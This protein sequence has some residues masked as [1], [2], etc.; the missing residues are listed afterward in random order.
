MN[1]ASLQL[2]RSAG[3]YLNFG[4]QDGHSLLNLTGDRTIEMWLKPSQSGFQ[5]LL[6]KDFDGYGGAKNRDWRTIMRSDGYWQYDDWDA[7]DQNQFSLGSSNKPTPGQWNYLA[8][9]YDSSTRL[10]SM[11][12]GNQANQP[13][14]DNTNT[15]GNNS[16]N[17]SNAF[18]QFGVRGP[19]Y[20]GVILDLYDGLV[21]EIR[22]W[23]IVRSL[24]DLQRNYLRQ[25]A[26]NEPGLVIYC[27]LNNVFTELANGI[28]PSPSGTPQ[29]SS[30]VPFSDNTTTSTSTTT[31]STSTSTTT[32]STSTTT[33]STS[34][35]TTTTQTSTSTSSSTTTTSTSTTT[36][37][38]STTTST[39]TTLTSTS[40]TTTTSTS[41][42][43]T[44]TIGLRFVVERV[45]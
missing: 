45:K 21:D 10:A 24:S 19:T 1:T 22:M 27:T 20:L 5:S 36:T 16:F 11:Y 12:L 18:V 28:T 15:R 23:N 3:Q 4:N 17:A 7:N 25:L 34:T 14:L 41:T 32:T 44:V 31:T 33:T 13:A 43:T 29:F 35:S 40:T 8:Y 6:T 38:T 2:Q 39:T 30:D 42:S 9:T 37:S 26:G